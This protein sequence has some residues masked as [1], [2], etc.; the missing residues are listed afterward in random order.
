MFICIL[1]VIYLYYLITHDNDFFKKFIHIK[2]PTTPME[3][4]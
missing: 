3:N 2:V 1:S 4:K